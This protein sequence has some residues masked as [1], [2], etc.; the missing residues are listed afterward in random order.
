MKKKMGGIL[1][2][3]A[4]CFLLSGLAIGV[5]IQQNYWIVLGA[6]LFAV[7]ASVWAAWEMK[8][9]MKPKG[10]PENDLLQQ[11]LKMQKN[12]TDILRV[13]IR[14]IMENLREGVV[15]F[16]AQGVVQMHNS[17]AAE[18]LSV[19]RLGQRVNDPKL[20]ELVRAAA[21]GRP[22]KDRLDTDGREYRLTALPVQNGGILLLTFDITEREQA[23]AMRQEFTAN[24]SHELKTPL[25]TISGYAELIAQGIAGAEDMPKFAGLIHHETERLIE[26]V[27]DILKLSQL[28]EGAEGFAWEQVDLYAV[29][30]QET[31]RLHATAQKAGV[32]LLLTGRSTVIRG[33]PQLLTGIIH[34]LCDNAIKYNRPGGRVEVQVNSHQQ[35]VVLTVVDTGIGIPKEHQARIFER[36]YR[37]DKSRSKAVGGTGLGLSIV[38]HAARIHNARVEMES[39]VDAGTRVTVWFLM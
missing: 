13:R 28:D 23:E 3:T 4:G 34:N 12:E 33:I 31:D 38:K 24:V 35:E 2:R 7:I 8:E 25:H 39:D 26:L 11:Q 37:V 14:E 29:A 9:A 19:L 36:F 20:T 32:S 22:V 30:K 15:F 16:D 1:W 17:A 18:H 10:V 5:Y 21:E 6:V 27:E